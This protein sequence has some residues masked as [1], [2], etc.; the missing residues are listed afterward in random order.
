M[1][2]TN[3]GTYGADAAAG[4][5]LAV[6]A[7]RCRDFRQYGLLGNDGTYQNLVVELHRFQLQFERGRKGES[8]LAEKP[9]RTC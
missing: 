2:K 6:A 8:K 7:I 9:I 4:V 5:A 3:V 1:L